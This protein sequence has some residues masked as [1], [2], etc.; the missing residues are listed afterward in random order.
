M[1]TLDTHH[2][3]SAAAQALS[4]VVGG[5]DRKLE[6]GPAHVAVH[7]S[8]LDDARVLLDHKAVL[9]VCRGWDDQP[10]RIGTVVPCICISG[11]GKRKPTT[12]HKHTHTRKPTTTTTYTHKHTH[13]HGRLLTG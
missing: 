3:I 11:L 1:R 2:H 4:V 8:R 7:D 13:T 10:V 9:T 12:T 5:D 6:V